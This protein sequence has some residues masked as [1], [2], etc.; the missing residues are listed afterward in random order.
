MVKILWFLKRAE[1]IS[2]EEFSA[3][4]LNVHAPYIAA[5]QG[6]FL[7]RY[8]VNIRSAADD[9]LPAGTGVVSDWDGVAEEVFLSEAAAREALSLPSA[10]EGRRDLLAHVSKFQRLIVNETSPPAKVKVLPIAPAMFSSSG[11]A[12]PPWPAPSPPQSLV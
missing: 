2:I 12:Q 11:V 10:P 7:K 1:G 8:I 4:W 6:R 3:W 5:R 9:A